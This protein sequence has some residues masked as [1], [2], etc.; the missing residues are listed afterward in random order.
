MIQLIFSEAEQEAL[1][2][3][4]RNEANGNLRIRYLAL[5]LKSKGLPHGVIGNVC[6][7]TRATLCNY[8]KLW[9]QGGMEH[10]KAINFRR[11]TSE[12]MDYAEVLKEYFEVHPPQNSNEAKEK[13]REITGIERSPTRVRS[14]M[15][16]IGLKIR[17]VGFVPGK[18]CTPEKQKEQEDFKKNSGTFA[19]RGK[20]R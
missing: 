5:Y 6:K 10:L 7:I 4:F 17:K 16:K 9:E 14:F 8:L 20:T 19:G 12:L 2:D 11:P 15:N 13:I 1:Y 18:A 3:G